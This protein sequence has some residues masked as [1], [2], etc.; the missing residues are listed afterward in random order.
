MREPEAEDLALGILSAF[1]ENRELL[2]PVRHIIDEAY[3]QLLA[4]AENPKAALLAW[5]AV[6]GLRG[7][8]MH[9][10][11]PL[12]EADRKDFASTIKELL[13]QPTALVLPGTSSR[14]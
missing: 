14:N 11:S 8:E 7:L 13:E 5:L 9:G 3:T 2:S 6:E 10:L 1:G 12:S 4:D